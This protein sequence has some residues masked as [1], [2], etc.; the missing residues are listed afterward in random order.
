LSLDRH[1]IRLLRPANVTVES[2]ARASGRA[3]DDLSVD[4][5][6]AAW[7]ARRRHHASEFDPG[8]L[9]EQKQQTTVVVIIP[10]KECAETVGGVIEQTVWPLARAGLVDE[11]VVVDADSSDGT[12]AAA[13]AAGARVVQQDEIDPEL[14]PALGKGDAMWRALQVTD[15]EVVCFLDA[16]TADPDAHH[17][18]GLLG[19]IL[20]DR[21]LSLVKGAFERPLD[22]GASYLPHEGGR[23]TELMARPLLNFHIPLLAAFAQPLAGEFAARRELLESISFPVG[24][25]VEIAILVDALRTQGLDALA[26]CNLGSRQNRHQPLRKLGEMAYAVL[27]AMENRLPAGALGENEPTGRYR[28][29]WQDGMVVDVPVSERPSLVARRAQRRAELRQPAS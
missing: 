11:T 28:R 19:P 2:S 20:S 16:D 10:A 24:Y 14:G 1:S 4:L 27:A 22:T 3:D 25:G 12:A 26:E 15:G 23:V 17:L 29:P 8:R 6:V 7:Y 21:S 13:A 18:L 9:R 5:A